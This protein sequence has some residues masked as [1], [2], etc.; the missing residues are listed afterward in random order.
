MIMAINAMAIF[1]LS[2][3]RN[4]LNNAIERRKIWNCLFNR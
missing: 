1:Y 3:L 4:L 2:P